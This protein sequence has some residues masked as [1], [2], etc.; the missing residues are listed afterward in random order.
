MVDWATR[1]EGIAFLI[2]RVL[3]WLVGGFLVAAPLF[4][5]LYISVVLRHAAVAT[6]VRQA[7]TPIDHSVGTPLPLIDP[8]HQP[9]VMPLISVLPSV[10]ALPTVSA[11]QVPIAPTPPRKAPM[12]RTCGPS[13]V[14]AHDSA[15][16]GST[17][18]YH[19][20]LN[21]PNPHPGDVM[22]LTGY[23][24]FTSLATGCE[25]FP[26]TLRLSVL[27]PSGVEVA[28]WSGKTITWGPSQPEVCGCSG[29]SSPSAS[30]YWMCDG[31]G[32]CSTT[33]L[34]NY[35]LVWTVSLNNGAVLARSTF[36][37]STS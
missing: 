3:A 5:V 25:M 17:S 28:W 37:M 10:Q 22:I 29:A 1:S 2:K 15:V 24:G 36:A 23:V 30:V 35:T 12:H 21:S 13:D 4:G 7:D 32:N 20:D 8:K 6:N 14:W 16:H 33:P 18:N 34:G 9:V 27:D 31:R 26:A 19:G 11:S